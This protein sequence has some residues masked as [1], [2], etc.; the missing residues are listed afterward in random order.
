[1]S[2]FVLALLGRIRLRQFVIAHF[3]YLMEW[4]SAPARSGGSG[5]GCAST[6]ARSSGVDVT[7]VALS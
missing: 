1:M 7:D 4:R 5:V 2:R 3:A 6:P